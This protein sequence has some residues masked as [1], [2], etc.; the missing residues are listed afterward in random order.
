[1]DEKKMALLS[2]KIKLE[3]FWNSQYLSNGYVTLEMVQMGR[4]VR[5]LRDELRSLDG[6]SNIGQFSI[7]T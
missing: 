1:M 6:K 4:K 7:A 2:E 3:S 5:E